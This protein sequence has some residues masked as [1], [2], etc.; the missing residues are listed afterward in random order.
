MSKST[1]VE[2]QLQCAHCDV[3][4]FAKVWLILDSSEQPAAWAQALA[5]HLNQVAC[6]QGHEVSANTPALLHDAIRERLILIGDPSLGHRETERLSQAAVQA[7][8][9]ALPEDQR[10]DAVLSLEWIAREE[11]REA[12]LEDPET[13]AQMRKARMGKGVRLAWLAREVR[14]TK[15]INPFLCAQHCREAIGLLDGEHSESDFANWFRAELKAATSQPSAPTASAE[16]PAGSQELLA[17]LKK[18]LNATSWPNAKVLVRSECEVLLSADLSLQFKVLRAQYGDDGWAGA[19]FK[20]HESVLVKCHSLGIDDA[21]EQMADLPKLTLPIVEESLSIKTDSQMAT[22]MERHPE[23][24]RVLKATSPLSAAVHADVQATM[25]WA[26][27]VERLARADSWRQIRQLLK[28]TPD[29]TTSPTAFSCMEIYRDQCSAWGHLGVAFRVE[30]MMDLVQHGRQHGLA[31]VLA[32]ITPPPE[33]EDLLDRALSA[34]ED[35]SGTDAEIAAWTRVQE[36]PQFAGLSP[37]VQID[38]QYRLAGMLVDRYSRNRLDADLDRAMALVD[39]KD[40]GAPTILAAKCAALLGGLQLLRYQRCGG[41]ESLTGSIYALKDAVRLTPD[42]SA[43][44][45]GRLAKL[46][47]ALAQSNLAAGNLEGLNLA[48]GHAEVALKLASKSERFSVIC[49]LASVLLQR[50]GSAGAVADIE[51]AIGLLQEC[52]I[53]VPPG[54]EEHAVAS[55]SLGLAL[56]QRPGPSRESNLDRGVAVLTMGIGSCPSESPH[57]ATL[58][59]NLG[60][61]LSQRFEIKRNPADLDAAIDAQQ[62]LRILLPPGSPSRPMCLSNL[63]GALSRRYDSE[64]RRADLDA[65]IEY[66]REAVDKVHPGSPYAPIIINSFGVALRR[67]FELDGSVS[68][69]DEAIRRYRAAA[70]NGLDTNPDSVVTTVRNWAYWALDRSDWEEASEAF[71]YG[72][73]AAHTLYRAQTIRRTKQSALA[74][75]RGLAAHAAYAYAKA[76]DLERAVVTLE[77]GRALLLSELLEAAQLDEDPATDTL[78]RTLIQQYRRAL[79]RLAE[80][81]KMASVEVTETHGKSLIDDAAAD[82]AALAQEIRET[83]GHADFQYWPVFSDVME[84][85]SGEVAVYLTSTDVGGMALIVGRSAP[86]SVEVVWLSSLQTG[87]LNER[88]RACMTAYEQRETQGLAWY[89]RLDEVTNWL[90]AAVM[91]E[92]LPALKP[93]SKVTLIPCGLLTALPLHAAWQDD[94][95]RPGHRQYALDSVTIRYAPNLRSLA[96]A[97][98]TAQKPYSARALIV[99]QPTSSGLAPLRYTALECHAA[100]ARFDA[101]ETLGRDTATAQALRERLAHAGLFHFAGHASAD[102]QEPLNGGLRIAHNKTFRLADLIQVRLEHMRLAVLSGCETSLPNLDLADE[103]ISLSSAFLQAGAAAVIASLWAVPDFGTLLLMQRYYQLW[104]AL[105]PDGAEALRQAQIWLRESTNGEIHQILK[106]TLAP[107]Q[108]ATDSPELLD[109]IKSA[110][111]LLE[112]RDPSARDFCGIQN[113]AAFTYSGA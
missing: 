60:S 6:P 4:F 111:A 36:H 58:L 79:Q 113:W 2:Q 82:I 93:A 37:R 101:H 83:P 109:Q 68:V 104:P 106:E 107:L 52:L 85:L 19:L 71:S 81:E 32:E 26:K 54:S 33:F 92:L 18:L 112:Q 89:S 15:G 10:D 14:R 110:C 31:A 49:T 45:P 70:R 86:D 80:L 46:A 11:L 102:M 22:F 47:D 34:G 61:A 59:S 48:V 74:R 40:A 67:L 42:R 24:T 99:E 73:Q 3:R 5:G 56:A 88:V 62:K 103:V 25:A 30:E 16:S 27:P 41:Q 44:R 63:G 39:I 7:Y 95:S 38:A 50:H 20:M 76:G 65:A 43:A 9:N 55:N 64:G 28:D 51:R 96:A 23:L 77:R 21:F 91:E 13:T 94:S 17:K 108:H 12:L 90:W 29:L 57:Y 78:Y 105:E 1:R 97:R 35:S 72:M 8:A 53:H 87:P 69:R 100:A 84:V 75:S 66:L 98:S